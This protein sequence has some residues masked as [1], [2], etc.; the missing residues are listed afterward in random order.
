MGDIYVGVSG[1]HNTSC[2]W[3]NHEALGEGRMGDTG[4]EMKS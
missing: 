3:V 4:M 1:S 2:L